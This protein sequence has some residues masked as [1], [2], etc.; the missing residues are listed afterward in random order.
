V[1]TASSVVFDTLF[2]GVFVHLNSTMFALLA[3]YISSAAYRAFR[4]R[5]MESGL[6]M[7]AALF[8]MLGMTNTGLMLT[9]WI[10]VDVPWLAWMRLESISGF[11]Q[12]MVNGP[13]F[14][15]V[16]IGVAVGALAMSMRLWLSLE[17]GAFFSEES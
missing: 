17:R 11:L 14:R 15:A 13:S 5:S 9:N 8:V 7:F 3:F 16:G 6:L 1:P 2:R 4:V 10:P 12:G